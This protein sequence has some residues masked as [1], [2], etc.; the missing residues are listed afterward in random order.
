MGKWVDTKPSV[1][2]I[3]DITGIF[4]DYAL[5][6]SGVKRL[7]VEI[8]R[9]NHPVEAARILKE[10]QDLMFSTVTDYG[11]S[12]S[13]DDF[14]K[15]DEYRQKLEDTYQKTLEVEG[16][17]RAKLWDTT[18]NECV[19]DWKKNAEGN[20]LH[21]MMLSGARVTDSQIRQI[22]VAKGLLTKMD[23][24]LRVDAIFNSL[25]DG[26]TPGEY[27]NT[28]GPAR[29]GLANNFF[30]VPAS[31]YLAR[32]LVTA[33]RDLVIT[34]D[35]CG[36]QEGIEIESKYAMGRYLLD[37]DE[38]ILNTKTIKTDKVKIRSA[39]TCKHDAGL[40]R[41][42]VGINPANL[43]PWTLNTGIG[44]IAAQTATECTTQ[45]ALRGKHTSGSVTL[46]SYSEAVGNAIAD[47]IK[48]LGGAGTTEVKVGLSEMPS[49]DEVEGDTYIDRATNLL[50]LLHN[51]YVSNKIDIAPTYIEVLIRSISD[52]TEH[53]GGYTTLRSLGNYD[54]DPQIRGV[55]RSLRNHPSW[56]KAIGFGYVKQNLENAVAF[57][58]PSLDLP[59]ERLLQGDPHNNVNKNLRSSLVDNEQLQD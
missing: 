8:N 17:D 52:V 49:P 7:M 58:S 22:I 11:L 29:R 46:A 34:T 35:D 21:T 12:L 42:C 44:V 57:I 2:Q 14:R 54:P 31:G 9:N 33:G 41:K 53:G 18:I 39:I 6:K 15:P 10:L 4:V 23:G 24:S 56:L 37:T 16:I 20:S 25:S 28:C 38:L 48:L 30:L 40:C 51:V 1:I 50:D 55:G 19:E 47:V 27:F 32:Q 45:L 36:S 13:Y 5:D 3:L 59:S 26:L 43:K